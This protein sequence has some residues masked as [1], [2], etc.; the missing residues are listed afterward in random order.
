M[1]SVQEETKDDARR[2]DAE[3]SPIAKTQ[4]RASVLNVRT[5]SVR[6]F[7]NS[8]VKVVSYVAVKQRRVLNQ[9]SCS[10]IWM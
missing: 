7:W 10:A 4:A 5:V 6:P 1:K 3:G 2:T 9:A 8:R